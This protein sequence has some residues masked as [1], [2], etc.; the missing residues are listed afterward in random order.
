MPGPSH[1]NDRSRSLLVPLRCKSS[2]ESG[3]PLSQLDEVLEGEHHLLIVIHNN[4]DP[5][6]IASAAALRHIAEKRYQA[7]VTIAYGGII[8]RAENQAMV[9]KLR[10]RMKKIQNVE[11]SRFDRIA[12]VDTQPGSA[13]HSLPSHVH[14][15]IVIDHH[16]RRP[17]LNTEL[18]LIEPDIGASATLLIEWLEDARLEIPAN[19]ATALAYAISSETQ[20]LG[21]EST[22]RDVHAYFK[23]FIRSSMRKLAEIIHPDLPRI[24]FQSVAHTLERAITCHNLICAH[25]GEVHVPEIVP[26]MADFLLRYERVHWSLCSG[27]FQGE[28]IISIRSSNRKA[29]AG[30]LVRRLFADRI[31][32]GLNKVG[33]HDLSAG[34][35]IPLEDFREKNLDRLETGLSR[36]FARLM[37]KKTKG[38]WKPL[39]NGRSVN[40]DVL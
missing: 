28:F 23:V 38:I 24:Y 34:G 33:G 10:L 11:F 40:S 39:L 26:E 17:K 20:N 36:D 6:S 18:A 25:L 5:D 8:G 27:I 22:R 14:C 31:N 19:L 16:P 7:H 13:N 9:G 2:P 12:I 21:R 15:H 4:P 1:I 32:S 30:A 37:R 35:R 29:K 3:I